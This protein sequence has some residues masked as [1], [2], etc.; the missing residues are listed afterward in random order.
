MLVNISIGCLLII[1]QSLNVKLYVNK[2]CAG[3][4]SVHNI[5]Y[6][7]TAH[8]NRSQ[9]MVIWYNKNYIIHVQCMYEHSSSHISQLFSP[10]VHPNTHEGSTHIYIYS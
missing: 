7:A 5:Y 3:L 10:S 8:V 4:F 9:Q 2:Y 1:I 6:V